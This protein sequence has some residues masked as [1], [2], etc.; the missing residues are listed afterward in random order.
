MKKQTLLK[1]AMTVALGSFI[2]KIVG[3]VYKIPLL[4][5][6]GGTGLGLY[7]LVYPFYCLLLTLSA[8]GIPSAISTL[9]SK[10]TAVGESG[11]NVLFT[12]L[13]LFLIIGAVGSVLMI[14]LSLPLSLLQGERNL[15]FGYICLA[16]SVFFTSAIAVFRGYF[17][18]KKDMRPTALSEIIEQLIKVGFG[19]FF[20][21]LY[22]GN[23]QKTIPLLLLSVSLSELFALCFLLFLYRR[24]PAPHQAE[25]NGG[26]IP[27][28][29]ILSLSV[30]VTFSTAILPICA[31]IE[32]VMLVKLLARHT[33][34]ALALYGLYSGGAMTLAHLP[35][36]LCYGIATASVPSVA[37]YAID[38]KHKRILR[39]KILYATYITFALSFVLGLGLFT[40]AKPIVFLLY[41]NLDFSEKAILIKLIKI[42]SVGVVFHSLAQTLSA[43]LTAQGKPLHSTLSLS[44]SASARLILDFILVKNARF[45]IFGAGIATNIGYFV[46]FFL[47]LVYNMRCSKEKGES[48]DHGSK[49]R[50]RRRR[51]DQ[52][53]RTGDFI[54]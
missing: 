52:K 49:L 42:M 31:F 27:K 29:E 11:K 50:R 30:P 38:G 37:E 1:G 33:T 54:G 9:V 19:L 44:V 35:V 47:D 6:I 25:Q 43:C 40:C 18:G 46:A 20:A 2:S 53:R 7:Q 45:S 32:S 34:Q 24:I 39:K 22:R 48:Y 14:L 12:A 26:K 3:A 13:K 8:T 36:S 23:L 28:K 5:L 10:K 21:Y 41:K 4:S 16:P 17:Q 51:F 15:R